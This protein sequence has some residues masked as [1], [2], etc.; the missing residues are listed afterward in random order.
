MKKLCFAVKNYG[1]GL[2]GAPLGLNGEPVGY[3]R[4]IR[5]F[6]SG[7]TLVPFCLHF[8]MVSAPWTQTMRKIR[9][10]RVD[11]QTIVIFIDF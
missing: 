9:I 7:Q 6:F 4:E 3:F 2:I 1:L 8:G 10:V 11:F 5:V